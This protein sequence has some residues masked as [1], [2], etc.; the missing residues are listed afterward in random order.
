MKP[1]IDITTWTN[2][3]FV[4]IV[5]FLTWWIFEKWNF[6]GYTALIWQTGI[7]GEALALK[8]IWDTGKGPSLL[9]WM[10]GVGYFTAGIW[11]EKL[12]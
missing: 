7:E 5:F 1:D 3:F 2:L 4:T 9:E 6:A 8:L 11:L 10:F 12:L